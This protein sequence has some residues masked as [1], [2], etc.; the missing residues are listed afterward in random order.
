MAREILFSESDIAERVKS[1]ARQIAASPIRPDIASPI[2][3]GGYVF[4]ADLLRALAYEGI[5]LPTELLWLRSYE[6]HH[7]TKQLNVLIGP[8]ENFKGKNVL[9]I[10]GVLDGGHTIHKARELVLEHGAKAVQ[11]AVLVDKALPQAVAKSDFAAFMN[12]QEFII[13]YGIDD[14]GKDRA[15]P[16]V[17]KVSGHFPDPPLEG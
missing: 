2:L 3:V 6:G 11:S 14:S 4:A 1:L 9:L 15:L 13:G 5:S 10:D 8:N 12:V 17:A 7:S 16:Y